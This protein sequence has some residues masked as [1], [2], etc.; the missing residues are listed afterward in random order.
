ML[1]EKK[2]MPLKHVLMPQDWEGIKT[3]F[4]CSSGGLHPGLVPDVLDIYGED[5]VL[6]VSEE[7]TGIRRVPGSELRPRCRR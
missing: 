7:S 4:P 1:R 5:I 6:L 3:V 2:V